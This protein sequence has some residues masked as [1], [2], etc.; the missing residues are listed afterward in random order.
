MD[1]KR[2]IMAGLLAAS[3]LMGSLAAC[4]NK[5]AETQTEKPAET[6]QT[7]GLQAEKTASNEASDKKAKYVFMFIGDGM[8]YVQANTAQVFTGNNS[9]GEVATKPLNY[10]EFAVAGTQTTQ[11]STSFCP[12]SASTA[13]SLSSGI[14]THSGVIGLDVNKE[15]PVETVAEKA[16]A[17][18]MKVG[19][20]S[21]VTLNHATPAAYFANVKSRSEYY[22]IGKQ[23]ADSD[24]DFFAGGSLRDRT[25][26]EKNEK[27]LYE[28]LKEKGYKVTETKADFEAIKP[29]EKVYAVSERL[30][31]DGAMPYS[32]DQKEGDMTLADFVTKGI[33]VLDNDKGFFMMC[34]SGKVDW[35]CHANDAATVIQEVLGLQDAVQ[36]AIDFYNKH[37]EDTLIIVTGDHET[38]GL[39]I[40][41]A[42]TGY[43]TAFDML[44]AQKMSY[45]EFDEQFAAFKEA[46]PNAKFTDILPKIEETFG[47]KAEG[48]EEDA[49][50]LNDYEYGKLEAAFEASMA[51]PAA[52]GETEDFE[53]YKNYGGYEPLSVTLTHILNNKAGIGWTSYS[54]T[55]VPVAVYAEG[56]GA[57]NFQGF[58]D[59]TDIYKATCDAMG[60]AQ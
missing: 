31:D 54:H 57:D 46:N 2:R 42:S 38:G 20:I 21:S 50:V 19:I 17:A 59:N 52:E 14:K 5:S 43:S 18:G 13:T 37:P 47:L 55:G 23:M 41:A 29:G 4:S 58:Y 3:M 49:F 22:E 12:D 36:V 35:A 34:E 11:D 1:L 25:G 32:I 10:A 26:K 24:F 9:F 39:T 56:A 27:D 60:L 48:A 53:T 15:N 45:V 30:Q 6:A 51:P 16:K 7:E 8:S 33:E 44:N 28:I 40:G